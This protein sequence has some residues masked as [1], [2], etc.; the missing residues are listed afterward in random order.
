MRE[1][2]LEEMAGGA[3]FIFGTHPDGTV[4]I[5]DGN[6]D[7]ITGIPREAAEKACELQNEFFKKLAI[8]LCT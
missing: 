4:D 7:V 8:L 5:S 3:W 1:K 6:R 2:Y